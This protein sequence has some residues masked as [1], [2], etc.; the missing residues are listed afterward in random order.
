MKKIL[1]S[2]IYLFFTVILMPAFVYSQ[3][4]TI[5]LSAASGTT[6]NT[7]AFAL[8]GNTFGGG[9]TS[10]TISDNGLGTVTSGIIAV[11]PFSF[12]YVPAAGDAGNVVT[13]TLTSNNP[14]GAPCTA[15]VATFQL[16]VAPSPTLIVTNPA[17]VCQPSTVNITAPA[18]TAGSSAGVLTYWTNAAAT[19]PLAN[20][21]TI[22]TSGTYYIKLTSAAGC[23]TIQPV[24]VTVNVPPTTTPT[25]FLDGANSTATVAAF[26]FNNVGQ[27]SFWI[28]Y[29]INGGPPVQFQYFAPSHYNVAITPGQCVVFDLTWVGTCAPTMSA[30]NIKTPTFA[31]VPSPICSGST[32]PILPTTSQNGVT[33]TWSPSVVSN[34]TTGNYTFTPN[35]AVCAQPVTVTVVV[36]PS[37]TPNF[38]AI[39]TF[40]SGS[41]APIL[42]AVSPNG[43]S[44][45]W[46]P[47][48]VSNTTSGSY[49]FTPAAGQCAATQVLN[50]TVTPLVT[51]NFASAMT[52]CS[53]AAVPAL[54]NVSPNGI[55]GTWSPAAINNTVS[56][57]YTFTP[58]PGQC[59]INKVLT[60]TITSNTVIN[61]APTLSL[62]KGST[63]PPLA[64]V[65]PNGISGIWSPATISTATVG[66]FNYTFTPNAGQCVSTPTQVVAVTIVPITTPNFAPIP[67]F[68]FG[69]P[70]PILNTVSPNGISGTWSPA[71][72]SNTTS[73]SYT[74]TPAAGQCAATQVL[75]TT[76][77]PLVTPNF[78][79]AMTFC[80]GAAVPAL[81]NVSPNGINGTWS[82]AAINN[83]VSGNYTF[84]PAPGQCA[85]TKVLTVTITSNTPINFAPTVSLCKGSTP[86]PLAAV[87][88]NGISGVWSPASISTATVGTFNYT[89]TPNAGQC[90]ATPT[91]VVAVTIVPITTPN[92]APIPAFCFGT[93]APILNT[94]SP[95]GI[96]GTWSP[97]TIS[98]TANGTYTFT[99]S[100]GQCAS[101]QVLTTTITPLITPNFIS[102]MTFCSGAAVPALANVSPNGISGTWSPAT[103]NNTVGGNYTF[104]PNAGQCATTK[105][106]TVTITTNTVINFPGALSLC[107]GNS[108][109]PL[110][111]VSPNGITG[112][113]SPAT[114]STATV[115]TFNYT[116]TA[117]AGQCVSSPTQVFTVTVLPV[118]APDFPAIAPF[119][120][121]SVAP[122]LPTTSPNG[123]TGTWSPSV[124]N[125]S[126]S[127]T[128]TFTPSSSQCAT[129]QIL[130]VTV[131]QKPVPT[132]TAIAPFCSGSPAP[133]LP[134]VSN[135]GFTGTWSP[136]T[137]SNTASAS[138]QFFPDAGQCAANA[139][140]NI[141]VKQP[142][143]PNF[144]DIE[145]CA[146]T[147]APTLASTSPNGIHGT[148]LP[149]AVNNTTSGAYVFTPN[150]NECANPQTINALINQPTLTSVTSV[151]TNYF[152]D[153][154]L[155]TVLADAAGNYLY[156]LDFGPIQES[157]VFDHVSSGTHTVTVIDANGCAPSI[158]ETDI[159]VIGYPHY[160]TPNGDSYN[161]YWN[162]YGLTAP[163]RILIFDR[164]G[165]LLKEIS[166]DGIGWD[167][168]Y[169]GQPLPSTD[170]WFT[171]NYKEQSVSKQFRAHFSLKR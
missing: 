76:V 26:D 27:T 62:C 138:Y 55:N 93:A 145:I 168:T 33:G 23:T 111:T 47:A 61:F 8:A 58:S 1:L 151:V 165:K 159:L 129:P 43:I 54:S 11:S 64:A 135:N 60:V 126:N 14:S 97:A 88:P 101:T 144:P 92:F 163:A 122:V 95:N 96:N 66:T 171:V 40:C 160:F 155:I 87:S 106:L 158:T 3:C 90:V 56:G 31:A 28:S 94:V 164:Y 162:I 41:V 36:T 139:T 42:N 167:G 77:T 74:F 44:G 45:T 51:P 86:P 17:A 147:A 170:Y 156:Q 35:G 107:K 133:V 85:T 146:G 5:N 18:V 78:A 75:N 121:D 69:T 110:A 9:A 109:P 25:L 153:N 65:S 32:A 117:N 46:S 83:T 22:A 20:P 119:C 29:S 89:F 24:T 67:A 118:T 30:N 148:W 16:T 114:I 79:S 52:F 48:T 59:A 112:T 71:T 128:Y 4:P 6:C 115:G 169:N 141:T 136:A 91:Q 2:K 154:Q 15:A 157:N 73:G 132:F 12:A 113:W 134:L 10:V 80:S 142:I 150:V 37:V 98:N 152:S 105:V 130:N 140:L 125:N 137:V 100:A 82:P 127:G 161:D 57:N 39:P 104:T 70:A 124:I 103:I 38:A 131:I 123:V 50:T 53:G 120:E 116:F 102:A 49:T 84:T 149:A 166:P 72:V 21:S 81:S 143:D 99:P 34:T 108:A 7:S 63:P 19:T 13:I 68:C